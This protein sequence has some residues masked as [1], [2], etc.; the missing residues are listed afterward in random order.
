MHTYFTLQ[1]GEP[2]SLHLLRYGLIRSEGP[3]LHEPRL[4]SA[5]TL[6]RE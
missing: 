5:A 1:T 3:R 4:A 6:A 2:I